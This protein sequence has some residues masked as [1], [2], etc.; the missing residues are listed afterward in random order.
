MTN[1]IEL[2]ERVEALE[3]P[4]RAVDLLIMRYAMNIGGPPETAAHYTGSFDA[5]MTLLPEGMV[6]TIM[7]DF[8]LPGRARLLGS[9]RPEHVPYCR[10]QS[11]GS[12]PVI[13]FAAA[14]LRA[15]A[16]ITCCNGDQP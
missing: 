8:G 7:T 11:D 5:V 16:A 3:G 15:R 4:C 10:W 13:A 2:A 14:C 9:A 12:S 1:W 6:F